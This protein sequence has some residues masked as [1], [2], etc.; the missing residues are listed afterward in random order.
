[1]AIGLDKG[2]RAALPFCLGAGVGANVTLVLLGFGLGEV[3]VRF[4]LVYDC[5]RYA[6]AAYMLWLAW[7]ISGL[8][9]PA[10][11]KRDECAPASAVPEHPEDLLQ[12]G[13]PQG[14]P[15]GNRPAGQVKKS[16]RG[17]LK[18]GS[19]N[20]SFSQAFLFQ[21]LNVK[22]W[23]T[24]IIIVSNYVGTAD[25]RWLRLVLCV[26]LFTAMGTSAM[27]YWAAGGSFLRR[28]LTSG[29]MRRANYVFASFL[30]LSIALLF[31]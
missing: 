27:C 1:M 24:N 3:F 9:M 29:G 23:L 31:I 15:V 10:F 14:A 13:D 17:I 4:P 6:G 28:F 19:G 12:T 16:G 26:A 11:R 5:L 7:K 22:V 25:D 21:L 30:V 8:P 18:N 2:F 20:F